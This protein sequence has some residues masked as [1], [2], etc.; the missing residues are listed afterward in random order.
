MNLYGYYFGKDMKLNSFSDQNRLIKCL[1]K[2][3]LNDNYYKE[4]IIFKFAL[5]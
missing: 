3:I 1:K 2:S 4:F 5:G